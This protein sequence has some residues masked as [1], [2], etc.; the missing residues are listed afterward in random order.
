M[1]ETIAGIS[2][3]VVVVG[4]TELIK[5]QRYLNERYIPLVPFVIAA[6]L[7]LLVVSEFT[8]AEYVMAVIVY[9]LTANGL[10]SGTKKLRNK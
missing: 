4:L 8:T 2:I 1:I 5:K 3:A 6:L 9:G 10:Y 7:G